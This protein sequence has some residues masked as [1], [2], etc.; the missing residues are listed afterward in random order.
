[1]DENTMSTQRK[2]KKEFQNGGFFN[3]RPPKEGKCKKP[4]PAINFARGICFLLAR[5]PEIVW[6]TEIPDEPVLYVCNHTVLYAPFAMQVYYRN[7]RLWANSFFMSYKE[8]WHHMMTKV[9][10]DRKWLAPV[11]VSIMPLIVHMFRQMEIVPV[12][13]ESSRVV[14]TFAECSRGLQ[15]GRSSMVFAEKYDAQL[16]NKYLYELQHGFLFAAQRYYKDTGKKLKI[17]PVY[18]AEKLRIMKV[19]APIEYDPDVSV[20]VQSEKVCKYLEEQIGKM[21]D[22]LPE[23][24]IVLYK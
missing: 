20:R 14:E 23:H 15:S 18:C 2:S 12:Y 17:Y 9:L 7:V 1:M 22:S 24:K 4:A 10:K 6:D 16:A 5:K 3:Y 19:G 13:R 21:G 8:C 11:A